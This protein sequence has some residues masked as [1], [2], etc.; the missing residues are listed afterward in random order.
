MPA[1]L[2]SFPL[3]DIIPLDIARKRK[4][5]RFRTAKRTPGLV[6]RGEGKTANTPW[7]WHPNGKVMPSR[8]A[9]GAPVT[10]LACVGTP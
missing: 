8:R 6:K 3:F 9:P 5:T 2:T 10:A 4:S 7:S 1:D